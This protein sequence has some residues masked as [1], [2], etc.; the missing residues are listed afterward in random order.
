LENVFHF[1]SS[2]PRV[3]WT[4]ARGAEEEALRATRDVLVALG[5]LFSDCGSA[6]AHREGER[7]ERGR[8]PSRERTLPRIPRRP[9]ASRGSRRE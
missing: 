3:A 1:S 2:R 6:D 5:D 7:D 9:P 8:Y 4:R